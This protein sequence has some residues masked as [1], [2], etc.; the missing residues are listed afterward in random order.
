VADGARQYG[1]G[2]WLDVADGA[3]LLVG[4][5]AGV[6]FVSSHHRAPDVTITVV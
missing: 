4:S 2:F 3:V 6:S 5:D 1:L